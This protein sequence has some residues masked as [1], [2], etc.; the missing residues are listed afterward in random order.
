LGVV[1][2]EQG[3]LVAA[4]KAYR[5]AIDSGHADFAPAAA[6]GLERLRQEG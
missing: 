4:A 5:V 6:A 1:R 2:K 3:D